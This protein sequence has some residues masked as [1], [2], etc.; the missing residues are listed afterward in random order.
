[1]EMRSLNPSDLHIKDLHQFIVG[2]IAPRPI[3]FAST[4]DENGVPN[5]APYSFF[6][7]F[8]SNPPILVFSSNRRVQGNTTKDTLHNVEKTGEVVINVVNYDIVK[9]MT[10]ASVNYAPGVSEFEKSGL[11]P[12]P[13]D[14]VKP[15]RV[16][17]SPVQFECKVKEIITLGEHGGAGHLVICEVLKLHI[18]ES[19]IDEKNR[20]DPNKLDLVGRLGRAYYVRASGDALF[21]LFQEPE[22]MALGFDKLPDSVRKSPYLSGNELA[23]IASLT[24]FPTAE[25]VQKVL[26]E[27]DELKEILANDKGHEDM[28][29][30]DLH[31]YAERAIKQEANRLAFCILMIADTYH[32]PKK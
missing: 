29:Y 8:S 9:Q 10:I 26:E 11:T 5:L 16:K 32:K 22:Q 21:T 7:A 12:I 30:R 1:M 14:M 19:V 3:A 20:I 13:S 4:I 6:N 31:R 28:L 18:R 17:E 25:D 2:A 27:D 15:P 24:E 23:C